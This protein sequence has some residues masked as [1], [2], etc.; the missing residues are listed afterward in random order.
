MSSKSKKD[1]AE[2]GRR[3]VRSRAATGTDRLHGRAPA[4][5]AAHPL[6]IFPVAQLEEFR[7]AKQQ[8]GGALVGPSTPGPEPPVG[9]SPLPEAEGGGGETDSDE[10]NAGVA[11]PSELR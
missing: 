3:K 5:N 2:A 6:V 10:T 7:K 4:T 8:K 9:M 1:L 11:T